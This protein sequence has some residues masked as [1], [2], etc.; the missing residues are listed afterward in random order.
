MPRNSKCRRVCAEF[1]NKV[2]APQGDMPKDYL[3][4]NVEELEALRLCDLEGLDQ[5]DAATRM[6]VSRG[7]LQRILYAA[8]QKSASALC[9]GMGVLI[10]GGNYK[11]A[12][13]PCKCRRVCKECRLMK[14]SKED[15]NNE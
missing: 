5:E 8:R 1:Q 7:T 15:H 6:G 11:I 4:M 3:T 14:Q 13:T 9:K 10:Q 2:F 12:S